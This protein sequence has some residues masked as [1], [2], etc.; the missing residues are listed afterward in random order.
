MHPSVVLGTMTFGGQM[1]TDAAA[2]ATRLF[3]AGGANELDTAYIY[4]DGESER[5]L[6]AILTE[7]GRDRVLVATKANPAVRGRRVSLSAEEVERQLTESL[8]RLGLDYV[9]LFYLH[10]P[11]NETPIEVTLEGCARLYDAGR[12]RQLGLSNYASWQVAEIWHVCEHRGWPIPSVYQGMYNAVTRAVE[13]ELFPCLRH[14]GIRF[15]AYN[16]PAGGLLTGKHRRVDDDPPAGRFRDNPLYAPRFWTAAYFDALE[17]VRAST[18]AAGV[19][20]TAAALRWIRH[21]SSID[22]MNGDAVIVGASTVDQLRENLIAL[23]GDPLDDDVVEALDA[24]WDI[25]R[26]D[27]PSYWRG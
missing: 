9:D 4:E 3:V 7:L 8:G 14:L 12:F 13:T 2:E 26:V 22:G 25:A 16:P 6:G 11:D 19:S 15:Y 24:A 21:H 20:M 27:C 17:S 1:D 18:E 10:S 5:I 23:D